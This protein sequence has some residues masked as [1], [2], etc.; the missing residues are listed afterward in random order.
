MVDNELDFQLELKNDVG[1]EAHLNEYKLKITLQGIG[2]APLIR[3]KPKNKPKNKE[4][5]VYRVLPLQL[6]LRFEKNV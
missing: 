1:V 4:E 6:V 2:G 3:S 5:Q